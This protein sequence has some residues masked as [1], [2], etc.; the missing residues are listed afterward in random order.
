MI[1]DQKTYHIPVLRDEVVEGL[2]IKP[3]KKYIDATLG[4]GGHTQVI[5]QRGG[6]ALGLDVDEEAIQYVGKHI[7]S[8]RLI[9]VHGNFN[10]LGIIARKSNFDKVSGIL[11]DLGVSSYQL[12]GNERGFSFRFDEK[13]D[14]RMDKTNPITAEF[15][16]NKKSKEELYEIF[17]KFAEELDSWSIV[18]SIVRARAITP[19][20]S[21]SKLVSIINEAKIKNNRINP[22]ARVFQ[23]LRIA[24]NGELDNLETGL[25]QA[26]ELLE[27]G[28][29]LVV[30]SYH[31]LEDRI[32][33][34]FPKGK[35]LQIINKKPIRPTYQELQNNPRARSAKLRIFEKL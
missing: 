6:I 28:G 1:R 24:V 10:N 4:G 22:S 34:L 30:I 14:M 23:A 13:L 12:N 32:T 20:V 3:G 5:L 11:F 16:I 31:S 9:L 18:E 15:I 2:N 35:Q 8:S 19:I 7:N 29:R 27:P 21:T 25:K 33:K 17:T 26:Y